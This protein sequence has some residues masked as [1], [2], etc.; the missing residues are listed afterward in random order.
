MKHNTTSNPTENTSMNGNT[1]T[2]HQN[3]EALMKSTPVLEK[4][5]GITKSQSRRTLKRPFHTLST[6]SHQM[7]R[8]L[9]KHFLL[10]SFSDL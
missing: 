7:E 9:W 1:A 3:T 2:Q 8:A 6:E 10:I 5:A 4:Y